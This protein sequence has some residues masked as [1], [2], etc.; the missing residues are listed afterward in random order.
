V[1]LGVEGRP[2]G[3]GSS[4][5]VG[6]LRT[7]D[8]LELRGPVGGYFVWEADMGGPLLLV[9]GG[10]GV[11]PLMGVLRHRSGAGATVGAKLLSTSGWWEDVIYRAGLE[12]RASAAHGPEVVHTLT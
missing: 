3:E 4:Y 9:A 7:G 1:A 11:V 12:R 10:S 6:E 5:L 8:M 2:D